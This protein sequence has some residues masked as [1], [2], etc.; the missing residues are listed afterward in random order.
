VNNVKEA[1]IET[2]SGLRF[3]ILDPQPDQ[4]QIEDIAHSLSLLCRFTG[5]VKHFYS[6]G[7]HSLL[8]SYLVPP[9][10]A[11]WF[12]LHDASE[13][14]IGDMNRPLKHGTDAGEAYIPVEAGI[15]RAICNKFGLPQEE[16]KSVRLTDNAMLYAE[17]EQ[18]MAPLSGDHD[19]GC[20][21]EAA[22]VKLYEM[23]PREVE[24]LFLKRFRNLTH[25]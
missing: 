2:Y 11:L 24:Y 9:Q 18:L 20:S 7:Q 17:K 5:H 23:M 15:M 8:G 14:F 6:V 12:L 25:N 3:Y 4:I 1:W 21:T 19:W 13:A 16:P 22:R 10:D